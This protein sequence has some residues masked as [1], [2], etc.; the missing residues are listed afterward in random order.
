MVGYAL[1]NVPSNFMG[2]V[3]EVLKKFFGEFVIIY[4]NNILIYRRTK[5]ELLMYIRQVLQRLKEEKKLIN[6]KKY[7]FMKKEIVCLGFIIYVDGLKM[8]LEKGKSYS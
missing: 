1:T 4:L 6:F 5:E 3:N 8:D 7:S 2:M